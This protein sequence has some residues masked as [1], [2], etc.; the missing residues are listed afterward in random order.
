LSI[1]V[2]KDSF[3]LTQPQAGAQTGTSAGEKFDLRSWKTAAKA[4]ASLSAGA[5]LLVHELADEVD[6]TTNQ[7]SGHKPWRPTIAKLGRNCHMKDD[8]TVRK[9]LRELEKAALLKRTT[10]RN[11]DA[12][13]HEFTMPATGQPRRTTGQIRTPPDQGGVHNVIPPEGTRHGT[14][15]SMVSEDSRLD[16]RVSADA[17]TARTQ[18]DIACDDD[19]TCVALVEL[20][21]D[22]QGDEWRADEYFPHQLAVGR[23]LSRTLR[24]SGKRRIFSGDIKAY[25]KAAY[26][27]HP[28]RWD[29]LAALAMDTDNEWYSAGHV[30]D[31]DFLEAGFDPETGEAL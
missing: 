14:Q 3:M 30:D 26:Q 2:K 22:L 8:R 21:L 16:S 31:D 23:Y 28:A 11:G 1:S 4:I 24:R 7:P 13:E 15:S 27:K 5:L 9:Y 25:F 20:L 12:W 10:N 18:P 6:F 17:Q 19:E 29:E